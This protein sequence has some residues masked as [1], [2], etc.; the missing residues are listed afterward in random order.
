M[1]DKRFLTAE[2]VAEYM[3]ISVPTAYKII[4]KL[5]G[6][7]K[8]MGYITICG[9]ISRKFFEEKVYGTAV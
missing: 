6:E 1:S 7:L 3:T 8:K 9:K 4:Q 5:N 2:D